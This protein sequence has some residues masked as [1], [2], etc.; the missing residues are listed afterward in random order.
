[1]DSVGRIINFGK[2]HFAVSRKFLNLNNEVTKIFFLTNFI[3][4]LQIMFIQQIKI[5]TGTGH[6]SG[7]GRRGVSNCQT[8]NIVRLLFGSIWNP[9]TVYNLSVSDLSE[10]GKLVLVVCDH[11]NKNESLSLPDGMRF[12]KNEIFAFVSSSWKQTIYLY[13]PLGDQYKSSKQYLSSGKPKKFNQD[14]S[15]QKLL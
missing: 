6:H 12:T 1:M 8:N 11:T 9:D 10:F 5:V 15:Q 7:D 2:D 3:I 13:C 14:H 4:K